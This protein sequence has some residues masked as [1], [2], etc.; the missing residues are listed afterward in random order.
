MQ[1]EPDYKAA[2]TAIIENLTD[3]SEMLGAFDNVKDP[4]L[5]ALIRPIIREAYAE[6]I[7][8]EWIDRVLAIHDAKRSDAA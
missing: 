1:D 8:P 2:L 5:V 7:S 3:E 6:R 4:A